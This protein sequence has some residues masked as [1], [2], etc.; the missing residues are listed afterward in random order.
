M[1][2]QAEII[3]GGGHVFEDAEAIARHCSKFR[4]S[5]LGLPPAI[6]YTAA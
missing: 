3:D 4:D 2:Q 5:I 1:V 6:F